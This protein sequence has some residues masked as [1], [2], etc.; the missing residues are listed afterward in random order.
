MLV[1]L[2]AVSRR[3]LRYVA[4]GHG[5]CCLAQTFLPSQDSHMTFGDAVDLH[6]PR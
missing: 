6:M 5:W 1:L 3:V 4:V 2:F